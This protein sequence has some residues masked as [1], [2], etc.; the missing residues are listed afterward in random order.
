MKYRYFIWLT[1]FIPA[2]VFA[3]VPQKSLTNILVVGDSISAAFN[4]D[5][6]AG[7]VAL[8]QNRLEQKGY[9]YRVI[10]ASIS[11]DTS[12]SGVSRLPALLNKFQPAIVII[13]LGGNDA[14]RGGSLQQLRSNLTKLI[15]MSKNHNARVLLCAIRVP[16]NLGIAYIRKYN[17]VYPSLAKQFNIDLVPR[18]LGKVSDRPKLMQADGVHPTHEGQ[19][20]ILENVWLPLQKILNK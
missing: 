8:L 18:L 2:S 16:P 4:I 11:G 1:V 17:Q 20:Q 13:E 3:T 15:R 7:W 12:R 19:P 10:N 5:I 6:T 9:A 14:L